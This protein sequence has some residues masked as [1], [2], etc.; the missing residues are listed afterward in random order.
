MPQALDYLPKELARGGVIV[1]VMSHVEP[2]QGGFG[3]KSTD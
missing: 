3:V 1:T 2:P